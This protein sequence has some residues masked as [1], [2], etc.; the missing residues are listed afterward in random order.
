MKLYLDWLIPNRVVKVAMVGDMTPDDFAE[1]DAQVI[2]YIEQGAQPV[3]IL[4]DL[5]QMGNVQGNPLTIKNNVTHL[6]QEKLGWV[7][8]YGGNRGIR[9]IATMVFQLANQRVRFLPTYEDAV[10]FLMEIDDTISEIAHI[11]A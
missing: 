5:T 6:E 10:Q 1:F 3:Y 9:F 4:A 11:K 2:S 7:V 8:M